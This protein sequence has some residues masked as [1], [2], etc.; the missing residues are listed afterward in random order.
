[1][2]HAPSCP[3]IS[4]ATFGWR[5]AGQPCAAQVEV[6]LLLDVVRGHIEVGLFPAVGHL[7]LRHG[8]AAHVAARRVDEDVELAVPALDL[9]LDAQHRRLVG[10]VGGN[11]VRLAAA[12]DNLARHLLAARQIAPEHDDLRAARRQRPA[13][14]AADAAV[15]ARHQRY[16]PGKIHMEGD[17]V[18]VCHNAVSSKS[19]VYE[20]FIILRPYSPPHSGFLH[21]DLFISLIRSC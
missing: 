21:C 20:V 18:C 13:E 6:D 9:L 5:L 10:H 14:H 4:G 12:R 7:L 3:S 17:I 16:A 1:M 2:T 15:S 11:R 8:R 19:F